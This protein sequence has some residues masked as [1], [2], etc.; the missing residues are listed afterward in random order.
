MT[1]SVYGHHGC[2]VLTFALAGISWFIRSVFTRL[3]CAVVWAKMNLAV[4]ECWLKQ[5]NISVT[6]M[7]ITGILLLS[8]ICCRGALHNNN[9]NNNNTR[10]S[11]NVT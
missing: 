1:K 4:R 9:N 8:I 10:I 6:I 7:Q 11:I 2:R 3:Q 5:N